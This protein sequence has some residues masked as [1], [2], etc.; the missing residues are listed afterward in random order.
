MALSPE[1]KMQSVSTPAAMPMGLPRPPTTTRRRRSPRPP[2]VQHV[3]ERH[4]DAARGCSSAGRRPAPPTRPMPRH[5]DDDAVGVE[6][7]MRWG[8]PAGRYR[9]RS[10]RGRY[11]L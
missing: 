4:G 8:S 2:P 10:R 7:A 11:G 5:A 9:S 6:P 3:G 1:R